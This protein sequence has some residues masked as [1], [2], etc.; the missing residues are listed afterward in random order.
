[1]LQK[2][3]HRIKYPEFPCLEFKKACPELMANLEAV[4][5]LNQVTIEATFN[6]FLYYANHPVMISHSAKRGEIYNCN[7]SAFIFLIAD[8]GERK[9]T[10]DNFFR[11][12]QDKYVKE[13]EEEYRWNQ[14]KRKELEEL[15]I[16]LNAQKIFDP[17][18]R[19]TKIRLKNL[20]EVYDSLYPYV[21]SAVPTP[22]GIEAAIKNGYPHHTVNISEAVS[23]FSAQQ[24]MAQGFKKITSHF[25]LLKDGRFTPSAKR[26]DISKELINKGLELSPTEMS[27][28]MYLAMQPIVMEKIFDKEFSVQQ[29]FLPRCLICIP[30]PLG[31]TRVEEKE[32]EEIVELYKQTKIFFK[33]KI[34]DLYNRIVLRTKEGRVFLNKKEIRTNSEDEDLLKDFSHFFEPHVARDSYFH[35]SIGFIHRRFEHLFTIAATIQLFE[36][37]DA[38]TIKRDILLLSIKIYEF[39]IGQQVKAWNI[40]N[41]KISEYVEKDDP[42]V[43]LAN[44]DFIYYLTKALKKKY[45]EIPEEF[46]IGNSIFRTVK[47]DYYHDVEFLRESINEAINKNEIKHVR[48][49]R[50]TK[51]IYSLISNKEVSLTSFFPRF[52]ISKYWDESDIAPYKKKY[53]EEEEDMNEEEEEEDESKETATVISLH[54]KK[55]HLKVVNHLSEEKKQEIKKTLLDV[56][57]RNGVILNKE[58]KA[59]C[60]FHDEKT[61]SFSVENGIR[62]KCFGCDASGDVF[63]FIKAMEGK[64]FGEIARENKNIK[65]ISAIN[66]EIKEKKEPP[67]HE[68]WDQSQR[69]Y[70][71][72]NLKPYLTTR[73]GEFIDS[74]FSLTGEIRFNPSL[75]LTPQKNAPAMVAAIRKDG[76]LIGIHRTFLTPDLKDT[77]RDENGKRIKKILGGMKGGYTYIN[78]FG[79]GEEKAI[80]L[81]EGIESAIGLQILF[82]REENFKSLVKDKAVSI[83]ACLN[84]DNLLHQTFKDSH[85]ILAG[86]NDETGRSKAEAAAKILKNF[87]K[88]VDTIYPKNLGEDFADEVW[89]KNI[90]QI[91]I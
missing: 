51:G 7:I 58:N 64:S 5:K 76:K 11:T 1:M 74:Y 27:F 3:T 35:E 19:K 79:S 21:V 67:I 22:E 26:K 31:G 86:D 60:P 9:T 15:N 65:P 49:S 52:D 28:S 90:L 12:S 30:E 82:T 4:K 13:L 38:T 70:P 77:L 40:G 46:K 2:L 89:G 84:A 23:V 6:C 81:C 43:P 56:L 17:E 47:K 53:E 68:I 63:D 66:E 29:G 72:K 14:Q 75:Y 36:N 42:Y 25:C 78:S 50:D 37:P 24:N 85:I 83:I 45:N 61:P 55:T 18:D 33:R 10:L 54:S 39:Y 34:A 71:L 73:F 20:H 59:L 88:E 48:G 16:Y 91:R 32:T 62:Y 41:K 69:E 80:I 57:K 8:S 44:R 87:N